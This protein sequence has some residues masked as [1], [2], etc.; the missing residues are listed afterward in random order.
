LIRGYDSDA[1][2]AVTVPEGLL[3]LQL[4]VTAELAADGPAPTSLRSPIALD[5]EGLLQYFATRGIQPVM[6][7]AGQTAPAE[8]G[9]RLSADNGSGGRLRR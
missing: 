1:D 3:R 7:D 8:G 2:A 6:I 9:A 4:L 5:R